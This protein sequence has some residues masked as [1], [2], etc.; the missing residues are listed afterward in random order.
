VSLPDDAGVPLPDFAEIHQ[1]A[2][3]V[4]RGVRTLEGEISL[5]G[6]AGGQGLRGRVIAGFERPDSM[7]LVVGGPF[8]RA[9]ILLAALDGQATLLWPSERVVVR[10]A[11]EE[12]LGALVGVNLAPADLLA[13]L[14]GCVV[15]APAPT[16]GRLHA[17][18]W[19]S[20][21]VSGGAVAYL[22]GNGEWRVRAARRDG[23]RVLYEEWQGLFPSVVR[24][25]SLAGTL[26]VDVTA[27][28][29]QISS[30]H[31][32]PPA[33]FTLT[34]PDDAETITVEELRTA[35]P[36]GDEE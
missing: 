32:I 18:G 21:D 2:T 17:N 24:L 15:P 12:I 29:S 20:I 19:A 30:N 10:D 4:C 14:T 11:P 22:E 5:R 36:L 8:G 7:S 13:V 35:G 23:W 16:A 33:A 1:Q 3:R 25:Q 31:D 6:S 9:E 28:L 27:T 26:V 34:V